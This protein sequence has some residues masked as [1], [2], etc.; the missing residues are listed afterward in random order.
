[1]FCVQTLAASLPRSS[2]SCHLIAA[3]ASIPTAAKQSIASSMARI[4]VIADEWYPL[5][6]TNPILP[7]NPNKWVRIRTEFD[8]DCAVFAFV[9]G[10]MD[11][12][13]QINFIAL[14]T[15][16]LSPTISEKGFCS[17]LLILSPSKTIVSLHFIISYWAIR[18]ICCLLTTR[19]PLIL[20]GI[21]KKSYI[22]IRINETLLIY[23]DSVSFF[24]YSC[25]YKRM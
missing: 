24:L 21:L 5:Q 4:S 17:W 8:F 23:I 20:L 15:G 3:S 6:F 16:L 18:G 25:R 9:L 1:M 10:E 13:S 2:P 11:T 14:C 7:I 12:N 19:K 22:A